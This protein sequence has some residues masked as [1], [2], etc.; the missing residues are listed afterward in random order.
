MC[1]LQDHM[2]NKYLGQ[3]YKYTERVQLDA[4]MGL[5]WTYVVLGDVTNSSDTVQCTNLLQENQPNK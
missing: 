2:W 4:H 5:L 1:S 3:L